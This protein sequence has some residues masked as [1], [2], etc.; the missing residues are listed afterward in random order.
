MWIPP[1]IGSS[2]ILYIA[3]ITIL[4]L[5]YFIWSTLLIT[6]A[7]IMIVIGNLLI[8]AQIYFYY[9]GLSNGSKRPEH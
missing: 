4:I 7:I 1:L 8:A 9:G 5:N 2:I 6:I 3:A